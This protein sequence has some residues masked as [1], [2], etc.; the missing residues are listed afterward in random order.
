MKLRFPTSRFQRGLRLALC[1]L[2]FGVAFA[3]GVRLPVDY[4]IKRWPSSE[5]LPF[6]SVE[7]IVQT[8]DGF[9]W[10]AM[11]G[12]L[13]RFDGVSLETFDSSNTPELT[14]SYVTSLAEDRDGGLWIGT[15]GGG[16]LRWRKGRFE[17]FAAAQGLANEQVKT[18]HFGDDGRL[19]IGTDGGGLFVREPNG[20]IHVPDQVSGLPE[21]FIAGI[22]H[23][24]AGRLLVLTF[25]NGVY[26]L[27]G[28]RFEAVPLEPPLEPTGGLSLTRSPL[29]RVWLGTG[30]GAYQ[31]V[32]DRFEL[33][34]P[35]R[36]IAGEPPSVVWQTATNE[37]WLGTSKSLIHWQDGNWAA[38][39]TGGAAAARTLA[40]FV[41]DR[42]GSVWLS[43]EGGGLLQM[44]PTPVVTLG[45]GEGL[46][47]DEI[48]SVLSARDG[49]LWVGTSH[50]LTRLDS[51]GS[52]RLG[53]DEGL[54]DDFIFSLHE[55]SGGVVWV[56][57]RQGGLVRW[58]GRAFERLA[59][60]EQPKTRN[61]WCLAPGAGGTMWA[62]TPRGAWQ[63]R[64]GRQVRQVGKEQRLSNDDV[65]AILDDGNG[66][67][68]FGTSY[69]L[70]RLDASG[71]MVSF[72]SLP[73]LDP[74]EVV[75]SLHR[76]RE[77]SL[78]I[79]TLARGLFRLRDGRFTQYST[80]NGLPNNTVNSITEDGAGNLWL[81]TG[82]GLVRISRASLEAVSAGKA[83]RVE[84]EVFGRAQGLRSEET[85]G[86]IQPTA[87]RDADGRLWFATSDGLA[88]VQPDRIFQNRHAPP[89]SLERLAVEGPVAVTTLLAGGPGA[90]VI[91]LPPSP[92]LGH[93]P[94]PAGRQRAVFDPHGLEWL[95]IPAGQERLDFQFVGPSFIAPHAV[96]YRYRLDG[97]DR[98]WVEAGSRRAAYYTRVPPGRYQFRVQA[99][100]E[101]GVRSEP[102][103]TL[104]VIV[105][106]AWW[107]LRAVQVSGAVLFAG[108][109]ALFYQVRIRQVRRRQAESAQLSR[110]LI[111]SQE[112]ERTRIAGELHDGL[113]QELQ[114]IRNRTEMALR[115]HAPT[116]E[117]SRE[118]SAISETAARAIG[119]VRA[120]ARGLRPPELD[121][122]GLTQALRWLGQNVSGAFGGRLE[123]RID[124]VDGR[125][126]R[127]QE[128]DFYRI[129]QEALSNA[130]KHS[131]AAEI[132]FE[133]QAV[134]GALVLSV[135]DNGRGF[136]TDADTADGSAARASG[137]GLKIMDERAA[138]LRGTLELRS[139]PGVGTRLTLR[140]PVP[141]NPPPA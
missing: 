47:G 22:K 131:G 55:D 30:K 110:R 139:E 85:T 92:E 127:E 73:G 93:A 122:L 13:G 32:N 1:G 77:N 54:P 59:P 76:D 39:P 121:Q 49:S 119:G 25:R 81:T 96:T 52:R 72:T 6:T 106:S 112:Q 125:L 107:Q 124:E 116:P 91:N 20:R 95:R 48:T 109:G 87:A 3:G 140:V 35:G 98:D 57:T 120:L 83:R 8:G 65:R 9:I 68:W 108:A 18:L 79:G 44:R 40:A 7:A 100:N 80:A 105:D 60:E 134:D 103:V 15:A 24:E 135:F 62:G 29:G 56:A 50:G 16:L 126:D 63:Y 132:T 51:G 14:V 115:R 114:M 130:M 37:V 141:D 5:L 84:A 102:G 111:R 69:G 67:V 133:V 75:I 4:S 31:F 26:L 36:E 17:R 38:Y 23:D 78:W 82:R 113:G 42:E 27:K 11:N 97:F 43:T 88:T 118:L 61:V 123:A 70:N 89:V 136:E 94:A 104:A 129:G 33:W 137:S 101:H 117:L 99:R 74:I 64:D 28:D 21:P 34:L 71:S 138:M 45:A 19:W 46:A 66:V 12:G 10:F 2:A 41:I 128:L 90:T 58:T 86:T 53:K